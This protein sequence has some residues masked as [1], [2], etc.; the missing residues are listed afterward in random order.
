MQAEY[1]ITENY[2]PH[3]SLKCLLLV[4]HILAWGTKYNPPSF[5]NYDPVTPFIFP[6]LY[7]W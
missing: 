6:V 1:L 2:Y 4:L 5:L 3:F 7:Q